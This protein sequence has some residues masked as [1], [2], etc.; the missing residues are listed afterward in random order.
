MPFASSVFSVFVS[1]ASA[2]KTTVVPGVNQL[3]IAPDVFVVCAAMKSVP[4]VGAGNGLAGGAVSASAAVESVAQAA[5]PA[6]SARILLIVPPWVRDIR[7][8]LDERAAELGGEG[9]AGA[10]ERPGD[11]QGALALEELAGRLQDH[12]FGAD[13]E[14]LA[15]LVTAAGA[16]RQDLEDDRAA[17][18]GHVAGAG[19][20][21]ARLDG[22]VAA[23][24]A[25]DLP[26]A[27]ERAGAGAV[28]LDRDDVVGRV[29][30]G[31]PGVAADECD[32]LRLR[33]GRSRGERARDDGCEEHGCSAGREDEL[34]HGA[35]L[36]VGLGYAAD[37][38][39]PHSERHPG[40]RGTLVRQTAECGTVFAR[41]TKGGRR[42]RPPSSVQRRPAPSPSSPSPRSSAEPRRRP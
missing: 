11:P 33:H 14:Q 5:I 19:E 37:A 6:R 18:P 31:R 38:R 12:G 10:V 9:A 34:L 3:A 27:E 28:R 13:R 17:R 25:D 23:A 41:S 2:R 40:G 36:V 32:R 15:L 21:Y 26:G 30:D 42:R 1:S 8:L 7:A 16:A 20:R 39:F 22:A 4:A 35:P 29:G 24:D